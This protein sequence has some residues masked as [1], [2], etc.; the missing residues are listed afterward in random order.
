MGNGASCTKVEQFDESVQM[1]SITPI[2]RSSTSLSS[3]QPGKTT[4]SRPPVPPI[5]PVVEEDFTVRKNT[6]Q[7]ASVWDSHAK[8]S[9]LSCFSPIL[10]SRQ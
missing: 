10:S 9:L 5:S 7:Y 6:E 2:K 8:V 1:P 4:P 3:I